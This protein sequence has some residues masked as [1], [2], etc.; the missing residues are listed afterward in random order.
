MKKILGKRFALLLAVVLMIPLWWNQGAVVASAATPTFTKK[1]VEIVGAEETYQ[2]EIKDKVTGSTYMWSSTN[3]KVAK[4]SSK[5]LVTSVG[6]GSTTIKCKIKYPTK[7]T[8][9]ISTKVTV[10]IPA[11]AITI[12]NE[13]EVRGAHTLQLGET[14]NFNSDIVPAGS[15]DKTY[16]SISGGDEECIRIVDAED[17]IVNGIKAGFVILTAT[18]SKSTNAEDLG[19]SIINDAIIIEVKAP[20]ASVGTVEIANSKEVKVAFDSQIDKNTLIDANNKLL[21]NISITTIKDVKGVM[22]KDPGT[23]TANLSADMRTLTITAANSFDGE[24]GINLTSSIKTIGGIAIESWYNKLSFKDTIPPEVA[25]VSVDDSGM[26]ATILFTEAIDFTNLQILNVTGV[27]STTVEQITIST[28]STK[29]NYIVSADKKSIS[30]NLSKI[31]AVDYGKTFM[32]TIVGIKDMSGII[33]KNVTL[34]T[35]VYTDNSLKPQ[36]QPIA[37]M[38]TSFYTITAVFDRAIQNAGFATINGN[39]IPGTVDANNNKKV[40]YPLTNAEAQLSGNQMVAVSYWNGYNVMLAESTANKP[41][42]FSVEFTIDKSS[43]VLISNVYDTET[44][45]LTLTYNREVILNTNSGIFSAKRVTNTGDI[46]SGTNIN[47]TKLES[48]DN[49][50]IKLKLTD[51]T[52]GYYTFTL[53]LGFVRDNFMNFTPS[54]QLII[55]NDNGVSGELPG[56]SAIIQS[57]TNFSQINLYFTNKLDLVSAQTATNYTI[58]GATVQLAQLTDNNQN[59]ATVLLTVADGSMDVTTERPIIIAGVKG[60]EG[61]FTEI[62]RYQTSKVLKENR[63]PNYIDAVF[64]KNSNKIRLNFSEQ[65]Q[66]ELTVKV[67]Q[68][69]AVATEYSNTVTIIDKSAYIALATIPTSGTYLKIEVLTNNITDIAGNTLTLLN[70]VPVLILY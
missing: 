12:N 36:A 41:R 53:D 61:S 26:I 21:S 22:A 1:T 54:M 3:T 25:G 42:N 46:Q 10:T 58:Q 37:V 20:S 13:I 24:Y 63:K 65:I 48:S 9:T 51:I 5:G 39:T 11:A 38:R 60:Y 52:F 66:G 34:P 16:W 40:N 28:I 27:N 67:T 68:V 57:A 14:F 15:S 70:T 45:T 6:K 55:N 62:S 23:L 8:K 50:V 56:P 17:G 19:K 43:P 32:I 31:A 29:T 64:D 49:K 33:P 44:N 69:G 18:A 2:L 7:K 4:V 30:I 59:G 47:Y 35:Y